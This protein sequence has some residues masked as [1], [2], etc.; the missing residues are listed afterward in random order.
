MPCHESVERGHPHH[1]P[2]RLFADRSGFRAALNRLP[3]SFVMHECP[4]ASD[5][6][7]GPASTRTARL[8]N[9]SDERHLAQALYARHAGDV[10]PHALAV[11]DGDRARAAELLRLAL[12]AVVRRPVVAQG[13]AVGE[14][15]T[16]E[17]SRLAAPAN[18]TQ[19]RFL[20]R[21]RPNPLPLT[22]P[23][24]SEA[25][26]AAVVSP[27]RELAAGPT[28]PAAGTP[29]RPAIAEALAALPAEHREAITESFLRGRTVHQAAELLGLPPQAVK[30]RVFYG[31]HRLALALE[32]QESA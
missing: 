13:R 14:R 12:L 2:E 25:G 20:L 1:G 9:R 22:R 11:A 10:Y 17:V 5:V 16:A 23:E 32:E 30:S 28:A 15:L 18:A 19:R 7:R 29:R 24:P 3:S 21:R 31:L 4:V 6:G 26:L 8:T 27:R